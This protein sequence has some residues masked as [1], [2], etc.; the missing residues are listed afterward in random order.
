MQ[1]E[2]F[3]SRN[4]L[5]SAEAMQERK[6]IAMLQ[7]TFPAS[8]LLI[9]EAK[10]TNCTCPS[11]VPLRSVSSMYAA[12]PDALHHN[13]SWVYTKGVTHSVTHVTA[14]AT[15]WTGNVMSAPGARL[16]PSQ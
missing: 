7:S 5:L 3:T 11:S 6:F 4:S 9:H 16:A 2:K 8:S 1:R 12:F 10:F 15:R 13:R 14:H